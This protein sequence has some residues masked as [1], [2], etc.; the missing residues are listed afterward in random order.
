MDKQA[1]LHRLE[2][3]GPISGAPANR[4]RRHVSGPVDLLDLGI[5]HQRYQRQVRIRVR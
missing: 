5:E 4:H 2:T 1:C 3:D